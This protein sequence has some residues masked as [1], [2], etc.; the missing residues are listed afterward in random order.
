MPM[1]TTSHLR[2]PPRLEPQRF[3][4]VSASAAAD[5]PLVTCRGAAAYTAPTMPRC[6]SSEIGDSCSVQ[7]AS[8]APKTGLTTV[9]RAEKWKWYG[10][11]PRCTLQMKRE[12]ASE[13]WRPVGDLDAGCK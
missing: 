6:T 7:Y 10:G 2:A 4:R 8:V 9:L 3:S 12:N 11:G 5:R 1:A 13:S